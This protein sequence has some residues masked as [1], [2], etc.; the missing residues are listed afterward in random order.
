[1]LVGWG[2]LPSSATTVGRR[3]ERIVLP[4]NPIFDGGDGGEAGR[5]I[6]RRLIHLVH[7]SGLDTCLF[8]SLPSALF[9]L[10]ILC[11]AEFGYDLNP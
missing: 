5:S 9:L 2:F 1:M 3:I 8:P 11:A 6:D 4:E 7:P 10:R